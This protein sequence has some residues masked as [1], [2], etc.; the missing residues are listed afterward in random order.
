MEITR[1]IFWNFTE[2][3]II[4]RIN[5]NDKTEIK[6]ILSTMSMDSYAGYLPAEQ[7]K[8]IEIKNITNKYEKPVIQTIIEKV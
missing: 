7:K 8:Y 2:I 1:I 3:I 5:K 6:A 4:G